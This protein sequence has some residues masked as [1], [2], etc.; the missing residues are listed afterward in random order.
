MKHAALA[1]VLALAA[2]AAFAQDAPTS[3]AEAAPVTSLVGSWS[4]DCTAPA[5]VANPRAIYALAPPT[6]SYDL[7]ARYEPRAYALENVRGV[8]ADRVAYDQEN[9]TSHTRVGIVLV[10]EADRIRVWS[11]VG[12][13]GKSFIAEGVLADGGTETKWFNRCPA[14]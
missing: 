1:A 14:A 6:L 7:G 3:S 11:S 5:S 2:S 13:D 8:S 4:A 10:L 9:L 12:A